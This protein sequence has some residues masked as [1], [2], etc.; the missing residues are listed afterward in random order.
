MKR[1]IIMTTI[2][3][4]F[5]SVET[6]MATPFKYENVVSNLIHTL[7]TKG[8]EEAKSFVASGVEI[9]EIREKTPITGFSSLNSPDENVRVA[10]GYFVSEE[11]EPERIAFIWE[12]TS[13]KEKVT[14]IRVVYDGSNPFVDES[15]IIKEYQDKMKTPVLAP[16]EFPFDITHIRAYID[17]D[18]LM[19]RYRN[20][21]LQEFVQIKVAPNI[22]GL[23][24]IK[25]EADKYYTL[26]NGT[27]AL[28]QP[29]FL[30]AHQLIFQHKNLKYT[31]GI[32]KTTKK[33]IKVE[34]LLKIA[35]S[36]FLN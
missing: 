33:D 8:E 24:K 30:P 16:S 35:N 7:V 13:N 1:I 34:D 4:L 32:S 9:P 14:D 36:M 5:L 27:K 20:A 23:E 25:G 18:T 6:V 22:T 31:I 3:M 2:L 19:L 28:Y 26:K 12:V 11:N 10:I 15:K 21:N 29:N 17:K